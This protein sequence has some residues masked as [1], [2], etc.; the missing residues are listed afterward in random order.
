MMQTVMAKIANSTRLTNK[1]A[2]I[3]VDRRQITIEA[4]QNNLIRDMVVMTTAAN[5]T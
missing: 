1:I 2:A 4:T 5:R 3:G